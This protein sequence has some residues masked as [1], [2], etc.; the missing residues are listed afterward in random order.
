M[1]ARRRRTAMAAAAALG[2]LA[3]LGGCAAHSP[4]TDDAS[5]PPASAA[6]DRA[7]AAPDGWR[8]LFEQ[9]FDRDAPLGRFT[10]VYPGWAAYDG[11]IDTSRTVGRPEAQ[12]GI[13]DSTTTTTAQDGVWDCHLSTIG[14]RPQVCAMTP[15]PD[16]SWWKGQRY[17]RYSVRFRAD[18]VPGYKVAWLLW[19]STGRWAD[20]E[21]DFPEASLTET[22]T[23]ASHDV[24]GD[25]SNNAYFQDTGVPLAG[26]WHTATTTVGPDGLSFTLDGRTWRTS[27]ADARPRTPMTWALQVETELTPKA[28]PRGAQGHVLI[29]WV[30]VDTPS[31]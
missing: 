10:E 9:D 20:G 2:C 19:P 26:G 27:E 7:P 4:A 16:G 17:G 28:P 24:T 15:T 29:D 5:T 30:T 22:V 11:S 31:R 14:T 25:P 21:V 1:A 23:A 18:A 13:W 8:R 6:D 12:R 3:A